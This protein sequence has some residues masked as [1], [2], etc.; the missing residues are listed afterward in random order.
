MTKEKFKDIIKDIFW[1]YAWIGIVF[2]LISII[3]DL[4]FPSPRNVLLSIC[5]KMMETMGIAIFISAIFTWAAE[6]KKFI[7]NMKNLLESIIIKRNFLSNIDIE[8]KKIALKSLIQPT[9]AELNNYPSIGSYYAYFINQTLSIS[10]KNVRSNYHVNSRA[11]FDNEKNKIAIEGTYS[12][13]LFP[14]ST[15]YNKPIIIGFHQQ[16]SE[17]SSCCYVHAINTQGERISSYNPELE[18]KK[19]PS[20]TTTC[21]TEFDITEF[22]KGHEYINVELKVIEMGR[23]NEQLLQFTALQPTDGFRFEL[24]CED[25]IHILDKAIFV[26]GAKFYIEQSDDGKNI[27]ITC[28][29]WINEGSGIAIMLQHIK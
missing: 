23:E 1:N 13:R 16:K 3:L 5:I 20:G 7:S 8:G 27:T 4:K 24:H 6:S 15:G 17:G 25:N 29:Q 19:L 22:G 18:E 14:S 2:L 21:T 26:V 28:N 11:Y 12:Y 9:E 10:K